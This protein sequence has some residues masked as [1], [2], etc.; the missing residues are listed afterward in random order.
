MKKIQVTVIEDSGQIYLFEDMWIETPLTMDEYIDR[1]IRP[2]LN[3][4]RESIDN[5]ESPS[6]SWFGPRKA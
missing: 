5:P 1:I 2:M 6:P 3:A 4:I